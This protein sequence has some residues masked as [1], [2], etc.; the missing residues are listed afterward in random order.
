MLE[1]IDEIC[2][3]VSSFATVNE[4]G[5]RM[6]E[7]DKQDAHIYAHRGTGDKIGHH[8]SLFYQ[9]FHTFSENCERISCSKDDCEFVLNLCAV[10]SGWFRGKNGED[11]RRDEFAMLLEEYFSKND[12]FSNLKF[13]WPDHELDKGA[14]KGKCDLVIWRGPYLLAVFE[15]KNEIGIGGCDSYMELVGYYPKLINRKTYYKKCPAPA[16]LVEVFGPNAIFSGAVFGSNES[17]YVDRLADPVWMVNQRTDLP[18]MTRVIKVFKAFKE[19]IYK[20]CDYYDTI[21]HSPIRQPRFPA[22]QEFNGTSLV[23]VESLKLHMFKA[24]YNEKKVIV[25]FASNY[26]LDAHKALAS[27]QLAPEVLFFERV[28]KYFVIV[29]DE[30]ENALSLPV[31]LRMH[32][33]SAGSIKEGCENALQELHKKNLCHGDF[34]GCNILVT[35]EREIRII[36]FDWAGTASNAKYPF[37]MNHIN[38]EWPEGAMDGLPLQ[39]VHDTYFLDKHFS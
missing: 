32:P 11:K 36:D 31:Y 18:A 6:E 2:Q 14:W 29:M 38:I 23:Y 19:A 7:L 37:F 21:E 27:I 8:I 13:V 22:F 9:D 24:T 17:I 26:C 3:P 10:M 33:E 35:T 12:L 20:L 4:V 30:V 39:K 15:F 1:A 34:R 5:K 16:Y 28:G 25:K